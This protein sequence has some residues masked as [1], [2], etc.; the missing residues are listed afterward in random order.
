MLQLNKTALKCRISTET[1][2]TKKNS[3]PCHCLTLISSVPDW[4]G[5]GK[6]MCYIFFLLLFVVHLRCQKVATV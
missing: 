4:Q 3:Q 2:W 6:M 5:V 1:L